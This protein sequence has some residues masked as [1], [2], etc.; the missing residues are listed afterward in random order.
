V[1]RRRSYRETERSTEQQD[2]GYELVQILLIAIL[3]A[4]VKLGNKMVKG[5]L[6]YSWLHSIPASV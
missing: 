3:A 1:L 5:G 2:S 6:R 4:V